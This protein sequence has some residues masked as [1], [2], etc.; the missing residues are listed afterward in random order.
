MQTDKDGGYA[1]VKNI[2]LYAKKQR[3]LQ[4]QGY[5]RVERSLC[6]Q[7]DLAQEYVQ[8]CRTSATKNSSEPMDK[9]LFKNTH[10]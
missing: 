1:F 5:H 7:E 9:P 8:V 6:M 10:Q 2:E 3:F 4:W